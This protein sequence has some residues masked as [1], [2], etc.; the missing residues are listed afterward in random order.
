MQIL[1]YLDNFE[2]S[3]AQGRQL[4]IDRAR[5]KYV[6]F[7]D[8]DDRVSRSYVSTILPLLDGVDYIGF[9]VQTRW[10]GQK[11]KPTFHSIRYASWWEDDEGY[12]RHI[13]HL[14]PI[15]RSL[16]LKVPFTDDEWCE[17]VEWASAMAE[18]GLVKTEYFVPKVM[19]FYDYNTLRSLARGDNRKTG[20]VD[21]A[22][23]THPYLTVLGP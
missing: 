8:D 20:V 13:S 3:R 7:V 10:D 12:Y 9:R 14:N 2:R 19:Y 4:L 18:S 15:R 1:V 16:A 11:L 21:V 17:D 6:S 23:P 5:S 22:L